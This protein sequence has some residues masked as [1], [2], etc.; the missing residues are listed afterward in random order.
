MY[1]RKHMKLVDGEAVWI[2]GWKLQLAIPRPLQEAYDRAHYNGYLS[3]KDAPDE[4]TASRLASQWKAECDAE[5][6]LVEA[7]P[8][9]ERANFIKDGGIKTAR[10]RL[11]V[12][13]AQHQRLASMRPAYLVQ[14]VA[15]SS[16]PLTPEWAAIAAMGLRDYAVDVVAPRIAELKAQL[17]EEPR[18]P[19][20]KTIMDVYEL[21]KS[22]PNKEGRAKTEETI[23]GGLRTA[24]RFT[25]V[26]GQ[27]GVKAITREHIRAFYKANETLKPE[28]QGHHRKVANAMFRVALSE[29]WVDVNPADGLKLTVSAAR[30]H[31]DDD[32][33]GYPFP[34]AE[35]K[36]V[37]DA[38]TIEW[39]DDPDKLLALRIMIF[40]GA[41]AGEVC[42]LRST[43]IETIDGI[44]CMRIR[45]EHPAQ[46][47]KNKPSRRIV[48]LHPA[49]AADVLAY[50]GAGHEWLFPSFPHRKQGAHAKQLQAAFNG[51]WNSKLS[52]HVGLLRGVC[53]IMDKDLTLH[54]TRASFIDACRRSG[55]PE[56]MEK[57]IA[58]HGKGDVHGRYGKGAGLAAMARQ[59]ESVSPLPL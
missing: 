42:Q 7:M 55:M 37:L 21:W 13:Q 25:Q 24:K 59:L 23:A 2:G 10:I 57:R 3:R 8:E 4:A 33:D 39:K 26:V 49:I 35:L 9:H 20:G 30:D 6:R 34:P 17:P 47:I 18:A 16:E 32:D 52:K 28:A 36:R 50:K 54:S 48:P 22:L 58:G 15:A 43:Q 38:A 44:P 45:A 5:I 40:S 51:S 11:E 19:T 46:R 12:L 29:G 14:Q 27:L 31:T 1:V 56:D 53:K 41:R